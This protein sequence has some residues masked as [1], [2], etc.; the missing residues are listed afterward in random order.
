MRI[1]LGQEFWHSDGC[2]ET[3]SK[4]QQTMPK[5]LLLFIY[6][7][8]LTPLAFILRRLG[9]D[10]MRLRQWKRSASS[11]FVER[12]HRYTARDLKTPR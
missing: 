9:Y 5:S 1:A 2:V 10:P 12:G 11:A 8:V 4:V 7:G 6:Y 3:L